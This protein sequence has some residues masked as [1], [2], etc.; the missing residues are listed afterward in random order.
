MDLAL[1][2]DGNM[3]ESVRLTVT[4]RDLALM[5]LCLQVTAHDH[6][7]GGSLR[8]DIESLQARLA[9]YQSAPS[10]SRKKQAGCG[11][12]CQCQQSNA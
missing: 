10:A 4:R 11:E 12:E 2:A 3:L 9:P 1:R 6:A 8:S 5:N 7:K